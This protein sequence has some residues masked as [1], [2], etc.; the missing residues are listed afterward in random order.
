V[1]RQSALVQQPVAGMQV[2]PHS[3]K[4]GAGH[5]QTP[6]PVQVKLVPHDAAAG[7]S[8]PPVALQVPRPIRVVLVGHR[9]VPQAARD[10]KLQ[11]PLLAQIPLQAVSDPMQSVLSQQL[12][13]GMQPLLQGLK[14]AA[15]VEQRP[16][17]EQ[18][19]PVGQAAGAGGTH[20]PAAH[21]PTPTRLPF[22]QVAAPQLPPGKLQT[23]LVPQVPA[24]AGV[25]PAQSAAVQQFALGMQAPLHSLNPFAQVVHRP[26]PVQVKFPPHDA[27]AGATQAPLAQAPA[28]T[29]LPF[30]QLAG[31]QPAVVG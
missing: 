7:L 3:L 31:E 23:P 24:Q 14:P 26:A 22:T 25:V 17:P 8:Q 30:T 1:P 28:A 16:A 13:V 11:T 10:A 2:A 9:A 4:P 29:R 27:A 6:A 20:E 19:K 18:L 21:E 5:P 15:Q 12:A